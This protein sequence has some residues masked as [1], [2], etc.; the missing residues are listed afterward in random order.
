MVE[1]WRR[2]PADNS[3]GGSNVVTAK[4]MAVAAVDAVVAKATAD[5]VG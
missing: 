1:V 4:A 5:G 2:P 3:D